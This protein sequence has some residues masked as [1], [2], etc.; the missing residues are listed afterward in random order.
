MSAANDYLRLAGAYCQHLGGL[1]WS[2]REDALEYADGRTFA[3]NAELAELVAGFG[4]RR[5]LVHFAYLLHFLDLLRN[6][7]RAAPPE[8]VRLRRAFVRTGRPTRNAGVLAGVLCCDV[9]DVPGPVTA[10]EVY[11][12]LLDPAMPIRWFIVSFHDTFGPAEQPPLGPARFEELLLHQLRAYSEDDLRSWLRHA[13]GPVHEA[14]ETVVRT[15]PPPRTLTGLLGLL[16]ER[17]RLAGARAFVGRLVGALALPRRRLARQ[18]LPTGG[19]AD[20]TTHGPV[21]QILP[22]QLALDE[23]DFFRRYAER[24]L[25]YF[26]REEPHAPARQELVVLLDQGVRTW[27]DVRLVLSAAVLALARQAARRGT[28]FRLATTAEPGRLVDPLQ[29]EGEELGRIVEASDL[30]ATPGPA[31]EAVLEQPAA[32]DRDVILLTHRRNLAEEDVSS[33]ARRLGRGDRLFAL[34]LDS[35]GQ[36]ELVEMRHGRPVPVRQFRVDFAQAAD[37]LEAVPASAD[38]ETPEPWRGH[39]EPV[40]FPFRF[41]APSGG[42]SPLFDFDREN[43]W[44]LTAHANGMLYAWRTDGSGW[45]ILPRGMVEGAGVQRIE[46][47]VGV[48]G[49]FVVVGRFPHWR[50]AVH[51]DMHNRMCRVHVITDDAGTS[52]WW[53]DYSPEHHAV[54]CSSQ[55]D[56]RPRGRALDLATGE[57]YS[58]GAGGPASRARDAW[59][60]WEGRNV[61]VRKLGIANSRSRHEGG[62]PSLYIDPDTGEVFLQGTEPA[63]P[64]FIPLADGRPALKGC[65]ALEAQVRGL[66][67]AV[68]VDRLGV[69]GG[70]SL[71]LF[72]GPDGIPLT[73]YSL[74]RLYLGFTLSADGEF[75]ARQAGGDRFQVSPVG[76]GEAGRGFLTTEGGFCQETELLLGEPRWLALRTGKHQFH[77]LVWKRGVLEV[78]Y[79]RSRK[80]DDFHGLVQADVKQGRLVRGTVGGLPLGVSYDR[81][82]FVAGAQGDV[83]AAADRFGQVMIFDRQQNLVCM[84]FAFRDRLAAWMP[85][86]TRYGPASLTGGPATPG[87]LEKIGR[88]L[89]RASEVKG[90]PA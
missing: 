46:A 31:L 81:H 64:P 53:W 79:F 83:L 59:F 51:Y 80:D 36:A 7:D 6:P 87:A 62:S 13:R 68:K 76:R 89:A 55:P 61:P 19:Y 44:L 14:A 20:V 90:G 60:A 12:R 74:G 43:A 10:Q 71:H 18:E 8:V 63:W 86:G 4:A 47:V 21:D 32:A 1:R 42:G 38:V 22:S 84:F 69:L 73:E 34:T 49:G 48:T 26:R 28:P 57:V 5:R 85:D 11:Q 77:T 29:T 9:P 41:G 58:A 39:I 2:E 37:Q 72:R 30:S 45:E 75:L 16:L 15:L 54:L 27:G 52:S 25:L 70:W 82:R 23:L 35:S 3:V 66:T 65:I 24:E 67:L 17:P 33:A 50:V 88:A 56:A 40:G 78:R